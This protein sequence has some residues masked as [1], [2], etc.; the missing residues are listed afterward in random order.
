MTGF[1]ITGD[2]GGSDLLTPDFFFLGFKCIKTAWAAFLFTWELSFSPRPYFLHLSLCLS[3]L[4]DAMSFSLRTT[5]CIF[6]FAFPFFQTRCLSVFVL[7]LA[8]FFV[9]FLSFKYE[10]FSAFVFSSC[11]S[12]CAFTFFQKRQLPAFV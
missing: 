12:L 7:L 3:L 4:S 5:S 9:P 10:K 8:S 1:K 2:E 11:I 6:L